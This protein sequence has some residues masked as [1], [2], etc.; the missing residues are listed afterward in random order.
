MRERI[1]INIA[2]Q[3]NAEALLSSLFLLLSNSW[4]AVICA[5]DHPAFL[6]VILINLSSVSLEISVLPI[7]SILPQVNKEPRGINKWNN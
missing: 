7:F 1:D 5:S 4:T 2:I 6:C 3:D